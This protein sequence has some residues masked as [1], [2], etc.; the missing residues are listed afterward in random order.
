[1]NKRAGTATGGRKRGLQQSAAIGRDEK[2]AIDQKRLDDMESDYLEGFISSN[3]SMSDFEM[4]DDQEGNTNEKINKKKKIA[5]NLNNKKKKVKKDKRNTLTKSKVN[6]KQMLNESDRKDTSGSSYAG[7]SF[8]TIAAPVT[9]APPQ[10]HICSI[11]RSNSSKYTCSRCI[12][13]Y[14]SEDCYIRH[15]EHICKYLEY[16]YLLY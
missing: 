16:N 13:R 4:D 2:E 1:M 7:I 12:D 8:T 5:S 11:C 14:C 3:E 6:L 15:K 10:L 9:S